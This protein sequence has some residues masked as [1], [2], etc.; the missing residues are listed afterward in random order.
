MKYFIEWRVITEITLV[1]E[2]ILTNVMRKN[3]MVPD[4]IQ[5][6]HIQL[7]YNTLGISCP[8]LSEI[9]SDQN[10]TGTI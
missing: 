8:F 5:H 4:E 6:R 1:I 3:Q 10:N 9:K 2:V 7:L